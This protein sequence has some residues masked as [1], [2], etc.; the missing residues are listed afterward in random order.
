MKGIINI[1]GLIGTIGDQRGVELIDII[2]QV[3]K[4]RE[5]TSFDV[6]INS[7]GGVCDTGYEIYN[8]IKSLGLPITTIGRN[9]VASIATMPFLAGDVRMLEDGAR[10]MIH[11]PWGVIEGDADHLELASAQMRDE[12]NKM[13]AMYSKATG[14]SKEGIDAL[15]KIET[16]LDHN[17]ALELGF[18]TQ[19][20]QVVKA[21]AYLKTDK[22]MNVVTKKLDEIFAFLKMGKAVA[23]EVTGGNGEKI[24]IDNAANDGVPK[25]DD[26]ITVDGQPLDGD[27]M[28]ADGTTVTAV[29]GVIT[30]VSAVVAVVETTDEPTDELATLKAENE[31][32]KAE[33]LAVAKTQKTFE[34]ETIQK[35]ALLEDALKR[36]TSNFVAVVKTDEFEEKESDDYAVKMAER[37]KQ[38]KK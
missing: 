2:S 35:L 1:N 3:S 28:L 27:V 8:Y 36:T 38:Y 18:S 14:I 26:K 25:V 10:F 31:S 30:N 37:R 11:N 21:V 20:S 13:I 7:E 5:A 4:Q 16:Y 32:L 34:G 17:R 29:A 15:M 6:I 12:E 22:T 24:V 33:L 9:L 23:L 19:P